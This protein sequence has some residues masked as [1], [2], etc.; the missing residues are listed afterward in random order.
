MA[1]YHSN[2]LKF[3]KKNFNFADKERKIFSIKKYLRYNTVKK[4]TTSSPNSTAI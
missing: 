1:F 3:A 2:Y 4:K